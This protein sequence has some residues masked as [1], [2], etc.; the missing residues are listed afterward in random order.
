MKTWV[1]ISHSK[2]ANTEFPTDSNVICEIFGENK[3]FSYI[4]LWFLLTF[5]S[6]AHLFACAFV[7][8]FDIVKPN[9]LI[10]CL[11]F[12]TNQWPLSTVL[13][14][15]FCQPQQ[16]GTQVLW[17]DVD[18]DLPWKPPSPR[19]TEDEPKGQVSRKHVDLPPPQWR[20]WWPSGYLLSATWAAGHRETLGRRR[21]TL[22]PMC[23]KSN[24]LGCISLLPHVQWLFWE[25]QFGIL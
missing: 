13:T 4:S 6:N 16:K 2:K 25:I 12:H 9:P 14:H 17:K 11:S 20:G 1:A 21:G 5:A 7:H 18:P 8:R 22:C 19:A 24:A 10:P 15:P 3:I 23:C